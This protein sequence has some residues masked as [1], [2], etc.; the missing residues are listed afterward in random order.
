MRGMTVTK[1]YVTSLT[2]HS[3]TLNYMGTVDAI[4]A[5]ASRG[6][7]NTDEFAKDLG[8]LAAKHLHAAGVTLDNRTLYSTELA[9]LQDAT[10]LFSP[11]TFHEMEKELRRLQGS[12]T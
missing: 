1:T 12:K 10:S 11:Y 5:E 6:L 3:V 9:Q 2:E 7:M 4:F 8:K